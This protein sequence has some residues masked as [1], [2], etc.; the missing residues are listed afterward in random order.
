MA[1]RSGQPC[2]RPWLRY[3]VAGKI[4]YKS[5]SFLGLFED[6]DEFYDT[7]MGSN[8]RVA[9]HAMAIDEK[10]EDFEPT[11]WEPRTGVDLKQVWFAGAHGDVGGSIKPDK[12]GSVLSN[13]PLRWMIREAEQSGLTVEPHL[14]SNL[15]NN[16]VAKLHP[17]HRNF[18]RLRGRHIRGIDHDQGKVLIHKSVR[19]RWDGD[20]K[21]RPANLQEYV[22]NIGWPRDLVG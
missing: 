10:R 16:P 7:K 21:Y 20:K 17:S 2:L 9:R 13:I 22:E 12:D 18:Y 15:T 14:V 5:L 8:I 11:I 19:E 3:A 4:V 6:K 1:E